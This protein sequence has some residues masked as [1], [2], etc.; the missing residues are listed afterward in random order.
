MFCCDKCNTALVLDYKYTSAFYDDNV[1]TILNEE[2]ELLYEALP[3]E[4]VYT[5]RRCGNKKLIS[6][7]EIIASIKAKVCKILLTD[8]LNM[9]YKLADKKMVD[10]AK[11]VSFCGQCVGVIDDSGY[12]YNDVIKQCPVRKILNDKK[13]FTKRGEFK[14]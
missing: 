1:T 7:D 8:R 11:G 3:N 5:C 9:T 10:E 12:C 6:L 13:H 14:K 4:V 2:G